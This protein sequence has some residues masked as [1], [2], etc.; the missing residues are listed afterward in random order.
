MDASSPES[1]LNPH[2]ALEFDDLRSRV[3]RFISTP[4]GRAALREL[5][6]HMLSPDNHP[7]PRHDR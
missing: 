4:D 2:P 1:N 6:I 3:E 7:L 5:L